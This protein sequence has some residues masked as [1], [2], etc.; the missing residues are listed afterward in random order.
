MRSIILTPTYTG[1][2]EPMTSF[3]SDGSHNHAM[4]SMAFTSHHRDR[5]DTLNTQQAVDPPPPS[6]IDTAA[7]M[8]GP[9]LT[10]SPSPA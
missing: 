8:T 9:T 2:T 1:R 4:Y 10:I 6:N 3:E 5:D 7:K